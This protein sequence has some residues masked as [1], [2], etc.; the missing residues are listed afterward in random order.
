[1]TDRGLAK[2][3]AMSSLA[4]AG[5]T[6]TPSSTT[7]PLRLFHPHQRAQRLLEH[8][9][10]ES[11]RCGRR[12]SRSD[13]AV[14]EDNGQH[15]M[16][17][18]DFSE[19]PVKSPCHDQTGRVKPDNAC[20]VQSSDGIELEREG[21]LTSPLRTDVTNVTNKFSSTARLQD[22]GRRECSPPW[23][24]VARPQP[25]RS[26]RHDQAGNPRRSTSTLV[27][28]HRDDPR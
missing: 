20:G 21:P 1:M 12:R 10:A 28:V 14:G 17:F 13:S 11:V 4:S 19:D 2:K 18:Q 24:Y 25:R 5:G 15:V 6:A 27:V 8:R 3:R 7:R 22:T 9:S 23:E 16:S 26:R